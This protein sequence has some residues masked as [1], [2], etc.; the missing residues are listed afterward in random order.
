MSR[1]MILIVGLVWAS[2]LLISWGSVAETRPLPTD[3]APMV[4]SGT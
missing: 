2:L 3:P 1:I 4:Q